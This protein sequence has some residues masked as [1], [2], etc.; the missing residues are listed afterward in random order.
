M[1]EAAKWEIGNDQLQQSFNANDAASLSGR[2][3]PESPHDNVA[4]DQFASEAGSSL[5]TERLSHS[6]TQPLSRMPEVQLIAG[7]PIN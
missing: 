5:A 6:A 2:K 7:G 1:I 3:A 4:I